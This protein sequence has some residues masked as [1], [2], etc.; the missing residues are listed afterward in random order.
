MKRKSIQIL[1]LGLFCVGLTSCVDDAYDL[2]KDVDLTISVGGDISTPGS[3]TEKITLEKIF[4]LEENSDIKIAENGDYALLLEGDPSE[5]EVEVDQI[6]L[7]DIETNPSASFLQF[8]NPG[9]VP[10]ATVIIDEDDATFAIKNENVTKDVRDIAMAYTEMPGELSLSLESADLE[11]VTLKKGFSISFP[12]YV[13]VS[14]TDNTDDFTVT[15]KHIITFNTDTE[16][17]SGE[18]VLVKFHV[19]SIDIKKSHEL[20]P[21]NGF[22][23]YDDA[24]G[25][26]VLNDCV[27]TLGTSFVPKSEFADGSQEKNA[28][29]HTRISF[30]DNILTKATAVI[31]PDIHIEMSPVTISSLPDFLQNEEARLDIED[32]HIVLTVDNEAEADVNFYAELVPFRKG[33]FL[34][35]KKVIVGS[36]AA[37]SDDCIVIPGEARGYTICIHRKTEVIEGYDRCVTIEELNNLIE[38]IP[39]EIHVQNVEANVLQQFYTVTLGEVKRVNTNYKIDAPLAFGGNL[40][41]PYDDEMIDW[42]TDLEDLDIE[43]ATVTMEA[44]NTIPL[45]MDMDFLPLDKNGNVLEDITVAVKDGQKVAPGTGDVNSPVTTELTLEL[46]SKTGAIGKLDGMKYIVMAASGDVTGK[47]LNKN[48]SLTLQNIRIHIPGGIKYDLN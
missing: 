25:K 13:T 4:E 43:K 41:L 10:E 23:S 1:F 28:L 37:D 20:N 8:R 35:D 48:Q 9:S 21:S 40:H 6:D 14:L 46:T 26:L 22:T 27:K 31:N 34:E 3:G 11:K 2:N 36:K 44:L 19:T 32:P 17:L 47:V 7:N 15:D 45:G 39:D 33:S 12:E 29:L 24:P 42:N 18:P 30:D 5:S 16:I 38:Q